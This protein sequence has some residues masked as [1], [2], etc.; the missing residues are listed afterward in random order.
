M[1]IQG[2]MEYV[3]DLLVFTRDDNGRSPKSVGSSRNDGHAKGSVVWKNKQFEIA[4]KRSG[5]RAF[6]CLPI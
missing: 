1:P 4:K 2:V 3:C 6:V 5:K